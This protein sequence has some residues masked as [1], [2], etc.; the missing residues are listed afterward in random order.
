MPPDFCVCD[1]G[2]FGNFI[3]FLQTSLPVCTH[4]RRTYLAQIAPNHVFNQ[5]IKTSFL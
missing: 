4:M 5:V 2:L 3:R 1:T